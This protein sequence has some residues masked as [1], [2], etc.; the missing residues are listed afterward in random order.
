MKRNKLKKFQE[1]PDGLR[2]EI[3]TLYW[4]GVEPYEVE[5]LLSRRK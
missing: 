5:Y 3:S 4:L 2:Y 1:F